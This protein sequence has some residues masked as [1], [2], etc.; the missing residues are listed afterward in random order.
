MSAP[1]GRAS[2]PAVILT[3]ILGILFGIVG[4]G[5][6]WGGGVLISEGGSWYYLLMGLACLATGVQLARGKISSAIIYTIAFVLTVIWAFWEAG[7]DFWPLHARIFTFL[8]A[9]FVLFLITPITEKRAGR[10]VHR[11]LWFGL[12]AVS[13]VVIAGF[14]YGMF[15]PHGVYISETSAGDTPVAEDARTDWPAYAGTTDAQRFSPLGQITRDNVKDLEVAWTIQTG[16]VATPREG[17]SNDS[18]DQNTPLQIGNALY[19]CTAHN[20]VLSVN[21]TTGETNWH[22]KFPPQTHTWNR[23]RGTVYFDVDA[24]LPTPSLGNPSPIQTVS[25]PADET[26][27]RQRILMNTIDGFLRALDAK[28]GVDCPNFGNNG[29]VDTRTGLGDRADDATYALT[30]APTLAGT[31]VV[32]GGRVRDNQSLDMPGGAVRAFDVITGELRWAFDPGNPNDHLAPEPG[33]TYARSTP[34]SWAPMTWDAAS[35]TV[36]MPLGNAAIDLWGADRT[37]LDDEYSSSIVAIDAATGA[38]KWHFQ[39]VHHD[40]WDF[41]IP[42]GPTLFDFPNEDGTTTPALVV[43]TKAGQLWVLDRVTGKPLTDVEE[44]PVPVGT[45]P[46]EKYSDTQPRS[47][48]MPQIG[49]RT[50]SEADMW[51]ATPFDQLM[52]R[53]I[54][55]GMRYDGLFTPPDTDLAL[56]LPG[57]LGGMN[58]GGLS[59]DPT[60]DTLL[61]NDMRLGLWVQLHKLD[62]SNQDGPA[63]SESFSDMTNAIS[64]LKGTPYG[65]TKNRFLSPLGIPCQEPPFG[66]LTGI[67]MKTQKIAWQVPVGTIEDSVLFGMRLMLPAPVGMPTLGGTLTTQ[68]GLTFIAGTQDFYIHAFDTAT[69]KQVWKSRLPVGSEGTPITYV[70][71]ED[72]KQYLV[73]TAGGSSHSPV[74]G[75]Y[76]VA[77]R[78]PD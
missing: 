43:G 30:S 21:A 69:G 28:T 50:M 54:F 22:R 37:P 46:D 19:I 51:G 74:R 42:Q 4:L 20:D 2:T 71:P 70:S 59:F 45:I 63:V 3:I 33:K 40:L 62:N 75:D 57:S 65:V 35:N 29:V 14:V 38:E 5:L 68:T 17:N 77:Y 11:G 13:V 1:E 49:T 64:P 47:V 8:C 61:V 67:N 36:F 9:L 56:Q 72:G 53:I 23:C 34:N 55:K 6:I 66:T 10:S 18:D 7:I 73:V 44:T 41:D 78:L 25:M 52:C 32:V 26:V 58:W 24:K 39:T 16:D 48:G 27:C 12:S 76:V 60:S 31:E 15:I